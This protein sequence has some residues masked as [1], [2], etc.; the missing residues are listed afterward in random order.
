MPATDRRAR[1]CAEATSTTVSGRLSAALKRESASGHQGSF[2]RQR[3]SAGCGF[4]KE[5]IAE[6]RRD[7]RDA[8]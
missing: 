5:T 6:M 4:G 8:P 2:L 3:L 1:A 7:G